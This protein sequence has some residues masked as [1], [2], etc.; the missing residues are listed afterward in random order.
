MTTKQ[1]MARLRIQFCEILESFES[2]MR[3]MEGP[4]GSFACDNPEIDQIQEVVCAH[5]NLPRSAMT[6]PVR[7]D[8]FAR[9]R[10]VAMWIA[11]RLGKYSLREIGDCFARDSD[12][13]RYAVP[14]IS[15]AAATDKRFAVEL[16]QLESSARIRLGKGVA[17]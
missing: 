8:A 7:T 11:S 6:S 9:P 12:T 13:V 1:K 3:D 17:A 15:N 2:I 14:A 4:V 5:Y 10:Q 16:A